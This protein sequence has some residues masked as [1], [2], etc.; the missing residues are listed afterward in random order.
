MHTHSLSNDILT[1]ILITIALLILMIPAFL[2]FRKSTDMQ[3]EGDVL[4]L[5]YPFSKD[6]IRLATDLKSWN[7][8][9]AFLLR[10][11]KVYAIQ[12]NLKNGKVKSISSRFNAK[13][14]QKVL[15]HLEEKYGERKKT[16]R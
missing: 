2:F 15:Q 10:I 9:E 13:D 16:E 11:G 14:F 1:L 7:L 8:Q 4:T 5:R 6:I 12:L 3:I